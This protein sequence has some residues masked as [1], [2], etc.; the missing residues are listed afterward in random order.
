MNTKKCKFCGKEIFIE[1][2]KGD[3][4]KEY[5]CGECE[6]YCMTKCA[7]ASNTS[8]SWHTEPC[9]SCEHNP[10]KINH[11]WVDGKW[12]KNEIKYCC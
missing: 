1:R 9:V 2:Y 3:E 10:Y 6:R 8:T 12:V 4:D 7:Q 11:K 5:S